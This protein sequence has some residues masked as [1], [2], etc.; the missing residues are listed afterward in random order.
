ME[1]TNIYQYGGFKSKTDRE[2]LKEK[3]VNSSEEPSKTEHSPV[4]E[5]PE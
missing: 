3:L 1:N 5:N 4:S 2:K